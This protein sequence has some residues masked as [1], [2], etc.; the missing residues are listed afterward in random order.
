MLKPRLALWS[1]LVCL[2]V[3]L[4]AADEDAEWGYT[5]NE[6]PEHW[7]ELAEQFDICTRGQN[8]SPIDL[9]AQIDA[10]LPKLDFDYAKAG[11]LI[12]ENTGHA[13]QE[14][15]R[16]GNKVSIMERSF[17]LKQ[18][19]FH[20]PSEHTVNGRHFPMEAHF[21]HQEES[22]SLLVVGVMFEEGE[23]NP[24]MDELPSFRKARG[25][26]PRKEPL[27]YNDLVVGRDNYFLYNGSLTTP[28][29][30]EGVQWI[31][32]K[33]P[34]IASPEQINHYHDLLGFDNNRPVQPR[35]ARVVLE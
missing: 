23:H 31:V 19:H 20:S 9:V 13:I 3:S 29:C 7:G 24:V 35:N 14:V 6:G 25:K 2:P 33:E 11:Q 16:P 17:E 18:F 22:G 12:E 30:S 5:G 32:M 28:P 21:V 26:G 8:Q 4:A 1:F 34:I 27:D 10:E 15:V